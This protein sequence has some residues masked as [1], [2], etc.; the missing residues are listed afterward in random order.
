M[1]EKHGLLRRVRERFEILLCAP[2]LAVLET[3]RIMREEFGVDQSAHTGE[4][5]RPS[6]GAQPAVWAF[7]SKGSDYRHAWEMIDITAAL[8]VC[9]RQY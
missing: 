1:N 5:P 4:A 9:R 8:F 6:S 3:I 2:S 7:V